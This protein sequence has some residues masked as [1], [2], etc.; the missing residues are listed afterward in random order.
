MDSF[1]CKRL[2]LF[3][4]VLIVT[5]CSADGPLTRLSSIN[6]A[7]RRQW[8]ADEQHATTFFARS[9]KLNTL[10]NQASKMSTEEQSVASQQLNTLL[11]DEA[12]PVL[13][14]QAVRILA[15]IAH[16]N[17]EIGLNMAE[18]DSDPDVRQQV[19]QARGEQRSRQA[20]R[21]LARILA[22]DD[23]F[24]V[25]LSATRE[26]GNYRDAEAFQALGAALSDSDPAMQ[27][28]AMASLA[29]ATGEDLGGDV[30]AWKE[31]LATGK[32]NSDTPS[33]WVSRLKIGF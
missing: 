12:N 26:L 14:S 7:V 27:H 2:W 3:S 29:R 17:A 25:R 8:A 13:R 33:S 15:K 1:T 9:E 5:G 4:M 20:L 22:N 16:P 21:A 11:R 30:A 18:S 28:R 23:D 24:D 31:F 6:P 32:A 19:C 10:E